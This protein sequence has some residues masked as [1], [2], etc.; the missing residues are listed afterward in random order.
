MFQCS[1]NRMVFFL[2]FIKKC[3][4]CSI[5]LSSFGH[6]LYINYLNG[7]HS[8]FAWQMLL[9]FIEIITNRVQSSIINFIYFQWTKRN[10]NERQLH[11]LLSQLDIEF[12]VAAAFFF[13]FGCCVFRDS[14]EYQFRHSITNILEFKRI[15]VQRS[16]L[17]VHI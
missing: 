13:I 2:F 4:Y 3:E 17:D 8:A 1:T 11:S 12:L 6:N 16:S 14:I 5:A 7:Y 9:H 10:I 15:S